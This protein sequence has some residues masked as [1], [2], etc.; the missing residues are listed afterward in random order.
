MDAQD[1]LKQAY[2][3]HNEVEMKLEEIDRLQSLAA[4]TTSKI[5]SVSNRA[6]NNGNSNIEN[7]V[8]LLEE[9]IKRLADEICK[10][11]EI[12]NMVSIAINSV[13]N[14]SERN[15]LEYRYLCFFTWQQIA[16]LM[17]M[18]QRQIYRLHNQALENFSVDVTKCH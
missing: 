10:L 5:K 2:I 13:K 7:A 6:T 18:S 15:L 14:D 9:Q 8:I 16:T 1:F 17:R 4:R 12:S 3:A 11:L